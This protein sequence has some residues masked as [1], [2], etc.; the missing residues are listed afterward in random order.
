MEESAVVRGARPGRFLPV[1]GTRKLVE[2]DML[3]ERRLPDVR[4][5]E[6]SFEVSI[7][8]Q[9][10]HFEPARSVQLDPA[11]LAQFLT[12]YGDRLTA[13]S[14]RRPTRPRRS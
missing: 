5:D 4:V 10:V 2:A 7:D 12:A 1:R 6:D 14:H 13:I 8:G 11:S 3:R 9:P